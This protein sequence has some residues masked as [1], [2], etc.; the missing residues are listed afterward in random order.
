M[1]RKLC[2]FTIVSDDNSVRVEFNS[3]LLDRFPTVYI[4]FADHR[5]AWDYLQNVLETGT[6]ARGSAT[7]HPIQV[8]P[9]QM[10]WLNQEVVEVA[11]RWKQEGVYG[12]ELGLVDNART[13]P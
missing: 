6:V 9:N 13:A 3:W 7:G 12:F 11:N 8:D 1:G 10:E 2:G 4:T 5:L